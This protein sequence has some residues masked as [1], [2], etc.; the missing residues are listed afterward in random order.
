MMRPYRKVKSNPKNNTVTFS[1]DGGKAQVLKSKSFTTVFFAV[2]TF[3]G[4]IYCL[5]GFQGPGLPVAQFLSKNNVDD[6]KIAPVSH[7]RM[8]AL[9]QNVSRQGGAAWNKKAGEDWSLYQTT[10]AEEMAKSFLSPEM[11]AGKLKILVVTPVDNSAVTVDRWRKNMRRLSNNKAGDVFDFAFYHHDGQN[12]LWERHAWY[13]SNPHVVT[14][15]VK[16]GCKLSFWQDVPVSV[17]DHY[18]Y[19]W[20]LDSDMDTRFFHW[21]LFRTLLKI[22]RP[23]VAQPALVSREEG[24]RSSDHEW[25]HMQVNEREGEMMLAREVKFVEVNAAVVSAPMWRAFRQRIET[26]DPSSVWGSDAWWSKVARLAKT[27]CAAPSAIA[28]I[29]LDASPLVHMDTRSMDKKEKKEE[30]KNKIKTESIDKVKCARACVANNCDGFTPEDVPRIH[31]A[32]ESLY[33][34]CSAFLE[35]DLGDM[36]TDDMYVMD[37]QLF[38]PHFRCDHTDQ[39]QLKTKGLRNVRCQNLM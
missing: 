2:F 35:K 18:D 37:R 38:T 8:R 32:M 24:A 15:R 33:S 31:D 5:S 21:D 23:P 30:K 11:A 12:S 7:D 26:H 25:L 22:L 17:A 14:R 19:I 28:G 4:I 13:A 39:N 34:Y 27:H 3:V 6:G 10:T 1:L 29:I 20:L 9:F 36:W 16:A